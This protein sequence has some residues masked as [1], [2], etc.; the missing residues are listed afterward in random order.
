M[1]K[2]YISG[3][4]TG[5]PE[6]NEPAFR[7]AAEILQSHGYDTIVPHDH[8]SPGSSW[9]VAMRAC[10]KAMM[11]ADSVFLLDGWR[12]SRGAKLEHIIACLMG[13][14]IAETVDDL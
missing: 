12:D 5:L 6:D 9:E 8:V 1:P 3:P 7:A 4:V 11:D 14:H 10:I 2:V 13:I